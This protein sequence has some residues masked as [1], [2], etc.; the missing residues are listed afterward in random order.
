MKK[1]EKEIKQLLNEDVE[2]YELFHTKTKIE[3]FDEI[4][5]KNWPDSWKKVYFKA[6]GRF[7]EV[8]LPKPQLSNISLKNTLIARSST[9]KFSNT[10]LEINSLSSLLYYSCGI[11]VPTLTWT[12][13]RFY[14]S[15]GSRYPLEVYVYSLNSTLKTGLYH[16]YVKSHCLEKLP[17]INKTEFIDCFHHPWIKNAGCIIVITSVFKRNTEKYG[18]RGYRFILT[19]AGHMAQNMYLTSAALKIG[20]CE[21]GGFKENKIDKILDLDSQ[22][23]SVISVL[24]VGN[25]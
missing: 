6:Y 12:A 25:S 1:F 22:T 17:Q 7:D 4:D 13:N 11:K 2:L 3:K 8:K 21:I 16:Y 10:K 23:E 14:P 19:E 20:C 24:V 15:G 9:R 18:N 5:P